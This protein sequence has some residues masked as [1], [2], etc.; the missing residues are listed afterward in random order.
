MDTFSA[1]QRL[2]V[3][4]IDRA[5]NASFTHSNCIWRP[6]EVIAL[7]FQKILAPENYS[8]YIGYRVQALFAL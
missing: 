5:K 6:L 7:K 4:S 1:V 2:S 3:K 8:P